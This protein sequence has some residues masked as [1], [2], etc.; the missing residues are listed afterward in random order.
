MQKLPQYLKQEWVSFWYEILLA[1]GV[2][3]LG[4]GFAGLLRRFVIFPVETI[5]PSV[6]PTLALSRALVVPEKRGQAINGWRLTRYKF[7]LLAGGA[8]YLWFWF[9]NFLL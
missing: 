6:L 7:F 9:P 3:Y 8:M 1:L 5:F 2:E 4:F